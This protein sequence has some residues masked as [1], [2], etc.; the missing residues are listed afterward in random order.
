MFVKRKES[1]STIREAVEY[2][3]GTSIQKLNESGS[4]RNVHIHNMD[5]A[6]AA[7]RRYF[8]AHPDAPVYIVGDY[9]SDGICATGIMYWTMRK[10]QKKVITRLP[11]RFSEG[12]GLSEKIIDEIPYGS[13]VITVDNGIA[14]IPAVKKAKEKGMTVIVT[15]HHLPAADENGSITLPEADVI[16]DP[17]ADGGLS[18]G[19]DI[20]G[21]AV[22]Y[23]F[24][25][26]VFRSMNLDPLCVLA[27]IATVTD[28]MSVTG[29]SRSLLKEGLGLINGNR[30]LPGLRVLLQEAGLYENGTDSHITEEDYGFR[31]GPMFNA[32]GRLLDDG[33][34]T[35]LELLKTRSSSP[36]VHEQAKKLIDLN[37]DRKKLAREAE[38]RAEHMIT[39]E[40]PIVIYDQQTGEGIIGLVAG[41]LTEKYGCPSIVFTKSEKD[42]ILKGSGRS[43]PQIHLKKVLDSLDRYLIGFGGHA[44]AAGLSLKEEDLSDFTNAFIA[45]CQPLPEKPEC[46][47]YDIEISAEDIPNVAEE[48]KKYA[49]YGEGNPQITFRMQYHAKGEPR[50]IGDGSHL[51]IREENFTIMAFGLADKYR[52][53]GSPADLDMIGHISESWFRG[54]KSYRFEVTAL[55]A[56]KEDGN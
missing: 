6:V 47:F 45:A 54:S 42:G 33:A 5:R 16:V 31:I 39:S 46:A 38:D 36:D 41:Y 48:L 56:K 50:F 52:A 35:V 24:A 20:C 40:R 19:A 25:A 1:G 27:S 9:D 7:V 32:P 29:T 44:G 2:H 28:V 22:A 8:D 3:S 37:N 14:A 43:I 11:H 23:R 34:E 17:A 51:M 49:P 4:F 26:E 12:Y 13:L 53:L 18:D 30:V 55:Q 10:L 21:A 15:D